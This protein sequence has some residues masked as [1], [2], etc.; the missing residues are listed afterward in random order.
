V[1]FA[2]LAVPRM[3]SLDGVLFA[4]ALVERADGPVGV[5][6]GAGPTDVRADAPCDGVRACGCGALPAAAVVRPRAGEAASSACCT[7]ALGA[8]SL[9]NTLLLAFSFPKIPCQKLYV[10]MAP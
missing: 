4:G 7:E 2:V 5:A 1:R 9:E 3:K 8:L 10:S 6:R